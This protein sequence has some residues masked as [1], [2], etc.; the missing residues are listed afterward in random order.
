M[1][2]IDIKSEIEFLFTKPMKKV[3][4]EL[5]ILKWLNEFELEKTS[6]KIQYLL[7]FFDC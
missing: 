7:G 2:N 1:I 6:I 4:F 3:G 5:A